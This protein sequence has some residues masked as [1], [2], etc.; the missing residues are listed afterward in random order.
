MP[1]SRRVEVSGDA[2]GGGGADDGG[3]G[4]GGISVGAASRSVT[5]G[6]G[7][8]LSTQGGS[9]LKKSMHGKV[10]ATRT[11]ARFQRYGIERKGEIRLHVV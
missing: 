9:R 7:R 3:S 6:A 5:G 2:D 8:S 1:K 11:Q 4:A 10:R